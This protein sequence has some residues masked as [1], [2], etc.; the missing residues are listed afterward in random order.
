MLDPQQGEQRTIAQ[1]R[2]SVRL[3]HQFKGT[4][5]SR[6]V[7]VLNEHHGEVMR[8]FS[9]IRADRAAGAEKGGGRA[10]FLFAGA[11]APSWCGGLED[12]EC[13]LSGN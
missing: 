2:M 13:D 11:T 1:L 5:M 9:A 10:R 12:H 3:P 6:F 8:T 4:H 7:E